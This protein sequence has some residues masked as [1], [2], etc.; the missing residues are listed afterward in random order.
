MSHA[1]ISMG[2]PWDIY[3]ISMG[4]LWDILLPGNS[5]HRYQSEADGRDTGLEKGLA[6]S[7]HPVAAGR[8]VFALIAAATK[9]RWCG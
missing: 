7:E 1:F 8:M 2:Y 3:G 9:G 6:I 5:L 4:Y